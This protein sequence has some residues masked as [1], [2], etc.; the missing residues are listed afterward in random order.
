[1]GSATLEIVYCKLLRITH[2]KIIPSAIVKA[3]GGLAGVYAVDPQPALGFLA[4]LFLWLAAW[5]V[6]GQ[7]IAND[8]VDMEDDQRV[9]ARTTLTVKGVPE[10]V[11]RMLAAVS[12]AAIAGVA[13]YWLAGPGLGAIY[14]LGAALLGWK[15][16]LEPAREVY[17]RPGPSTA[18]ALFNRASYLPVSFLVLI[19]LSMY[20]PF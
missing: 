6:G 19:V 16:M 11:F 7:N 15:L 12:M 4:V 10:S 13:I 1:V 18:A 5:E 14:P 17:Y 8:I 3:T 9:S 20:A 2:L